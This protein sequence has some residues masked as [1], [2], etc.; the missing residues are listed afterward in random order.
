[1]IH[2]CSRFF[3]AAET[4]GE[5]PDRLREVA[6][7][8]FWLSVGTIEP[9]KN[10]RRLAEAFAGYLARGGE[11]MPL[12]LAGGQGWHMEDFPRFLDELG[13]ARHVI[14]TTPLSSVPPAPN[15]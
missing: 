8:R 9:R 10:Q 3:A 12:V 2:P 6:P 1:M 14:V 4:P 7:G 15:L 5:R 13:I 11:P